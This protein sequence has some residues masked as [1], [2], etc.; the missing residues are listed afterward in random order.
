MPQEYT[1]ETLDRRSGDLTT[2]SLG[3]WKTVSELATDYQCG[4]REFRVILKAM[5]LLASEGRHGWQRLTHEAVAMGY[6]KRLTPKR[7]KNG[8]LY[9]FDVISPLGQALIAS[10][11]DEARAEVEAAK[12]SKPSVRAAEARLWSFAE[13]RRRTM[14]VQEQ[15]CW[16]LDHH[17]SLTLSEVSLITSS[18]LKLVSKYA[19]L[20]REQREY[21]TRQKTKEL[22]RIPDDAGWS[23]TEKEMREAAH[24]GLSILPRFFNQSKA[25]A[26]DLYGIEGDVWTQE[27]L[28]AA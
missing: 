23:L 17:P 1:A 22:P 6:G 12:R 5:N 9:P 20:R 19:K 15:V 8:K 4:P 14:T 2:T 28:K 7:T 26:F 11:W 3:V 27:T 16:L 21:L 10:L 24:V 25:V 18:D 13:G